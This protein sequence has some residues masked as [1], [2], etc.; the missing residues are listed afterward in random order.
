MRSRAAFG[1]PS[2]RVEGI[3]TSEIALSASERHASGRKKLAN[4]LGRWRNASEKLANFANFGKL[5]NFF[6]PERESPRVR[7]QIRL[8]DSRAR[9]S[10]ATWCSRRGTH[11]ANSAV[12]LVS[13]PVDSSRIVV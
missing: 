9:A 7:R 6:D 5:A 11:P 2:C 10:S 1:K 12:R 4:I 13:R 3:D 8:F